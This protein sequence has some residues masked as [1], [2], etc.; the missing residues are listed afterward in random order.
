[1]KAD[2]P[3]WDD[4]VWGEA[5]TDLLWETFHENSK[6][7]GYDDA[8]PNQVVVDWMTRLKNALVYDSADAVPL[9]GPERFPP[10]TRGLG[11]A[12]AR[13][14]TPRGLVPTPMALETLASLLHHAYGINR[15][16]EGTHFPRPFRNVPSGGGLFPLELYVHDRGLVD[17]LQPGL[18][19]YDPETNCLRRIMDGDMTEAFAPCLYQPEIIRGA[20]V[21][22]FQTALFRRSTFKYRDR[23]YRFTLIE[24]GHVAQNLNLVATALELGVWNIGGFQ[25][26]RIDRLLGIDGVNHATVYMHAIGREAV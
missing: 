19:H 25:D 6:S 17:G 5:E 11:E 21:T 14:H 4:L 22:I 1:M 3:S 16:N 7:S 9:P 13:R 26:R 15:W 12:I 23:G 24:A 2:G 18:H 20:T 10:F 8:L